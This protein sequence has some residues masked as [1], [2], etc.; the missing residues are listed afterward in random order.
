MF[1]GGAAAFLNGG[2]FP[3]FSIIFGDMTDSFSAA[4]DEMVY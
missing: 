2:A 4:G 3:S 1:I